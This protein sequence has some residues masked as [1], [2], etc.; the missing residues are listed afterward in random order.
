MASTSLPHLRTSQRCVSLMKPPV[1]QHELFVS[2]YK[3]G[4]T[5]THQSNAEA[6]P[7]AAT[8][9]NSSTVRDVLPWMWKDGTLGTHGEMLS[10]EFPVQRLRPLWTLRKSVQIPEAHKSASLEDR[11]SE[12][13]EG[14][15]LHHPRGANGSTSGGPQ[16]SRVARRQRPKSSGDHM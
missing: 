14:E 8:A 7:P 10:E 4:K 11:I 3:K 9:G 15:S 2:L 13:R 12:N 1:R 16:A 5:A 6:R